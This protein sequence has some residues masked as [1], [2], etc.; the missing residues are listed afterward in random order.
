MKLNFS[1]CALGWLYIV[2]IKLISHVNRSVSL[3]SRDHKFCLTPMVRSMFKHYSVCCSDRFANSTVQRSLK[4]TGCLMVVPRP[5][6]FRRQTS[7]PTLVNKTNLVHNLLLV[8]LWIVNQLDAV[9]FSNIFIC[10]SLS[11][12]FGH[13]VLII[14]RDPIALTQLLYLSFRFSCVSCEHCGFTHSHKLC[15]SSRLTQC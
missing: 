2:I 14:R 12:C 3:K 5:P 15:H 11:T 8:C 4:V 6:P 1:R 9:I 7:K 13:Y 10:L